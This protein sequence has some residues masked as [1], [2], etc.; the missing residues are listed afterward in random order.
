MTTPVIQEILE[1][2]LDDWL[3]FVDVADAIRV[4]EGVEREA[5]EEQAI[6]V[7]EDL[8]R[9]GLIEVGSVAKGQGFLSWGISVEETMTRIRQEIA[10]L[11][12]QPSLGDVCWI[13]TTPAGDK[14]VQNP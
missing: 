7:I 14:E 6:E 3:D 8:V 13:S 12:R 4:V 2:G 9:A 11:G 10:A 5:A 1:R